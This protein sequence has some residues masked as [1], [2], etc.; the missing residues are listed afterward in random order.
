MDGDQMLFA[1]V[2]EDRTLVLAHLFVR[3]PRP[4]DNERTLSVLRQA[5]TWY[6]Q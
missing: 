3:V 2:G 5:A 6:Y 1:E 4:G